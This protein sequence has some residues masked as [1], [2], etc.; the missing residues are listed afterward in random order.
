MQLLLQQAMDDSRSLRWTVFCWDQAEPFW[1][2][3]LWTRL[4][5]SR[6]RCLC[7]CRQLSSRVSLC[8]GQGICNRGLWVLLIRM[9][10]VGLAWWTLS[11]WR[12]RDHTSHL[13]RVDSNASLEE[14]KFRCRVLCIELQIHPFPKVEQTNQSLTVWDWT[15]YPTEDLRAWGFYDIYLPYG[16][17]WCHSSTKWSNI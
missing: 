1:R 2:R 16:S 13:R 4:R 6:H 5:R 10:D 15:G 9:G 14:G 12:Q 17:D 3:G 7:S 8:W 11:C